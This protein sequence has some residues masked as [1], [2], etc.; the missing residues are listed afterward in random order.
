MTAAESPALPA[1][2]ARDSDGVGS[3]KGL[4]TVP[5]GGGGCQRDRGPDGKSQN[6]VSG[7][8]SEEVLDYGPACA[9]NARGFTGHR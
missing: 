4:K 1:G 3:G 7:N 8:I 5:G 9:M 6:S 2:M